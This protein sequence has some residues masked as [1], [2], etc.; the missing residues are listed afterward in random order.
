MPVC[1]VE[2]K[3]DL[4]W[5]LAS[6]TLSPTD[7]WSMRIGF[8]ARGS[9]PPCPAPLS[10]SGFLAEPAGLCVLLFQLLVKDLRGEMTLPMAADRQSSLQDSI[11]GRRVAW[12]LSLGGS[13][14]LPEV[15]RRDGGSGGS[16]GPCIPMGCARH[17]PL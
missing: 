16:Q 11:L 4:V 17:Q 15:G 8:Q 2:G 7:E 3:A 6:V 13:Q 1:R 9:P 12:L 14:V 10:C 5:E